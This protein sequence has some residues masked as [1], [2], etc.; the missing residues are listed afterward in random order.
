[1]KKVV[2]IIIA[3][4]CITGLLAQNP[5][6]KSD[7]LRFLLRSTPTGIERV[8]I[9]NELSAYLIIGDLYDSAMTIANEALTLSEHLNYQP[10]KASAYRKM[11]VNYTQQGD[12][13]RALECLLNSLRINEALK[14]REEIFKLHNNIGNMYYSQG[15]Y[16]SALDYFMKAYSYK[17]D[18]GLTNA[19]IGNTYMAKKDFQL[20]IRYLQKALIIYSKDNNQNGIADMLSN[21]GTIYEYKNENDTALCYYRKS[22]KI[23]EEIRD[24]QGQCDLLGGIGDILFKQKKY[25][26]AI[27]Y[28]NKSLELAYQIG[29]LISA[30]QTECKLNEI[31]DSIG[32]KE[33]AYLHYRRYIGIKEDLWN[34]EESKKTVRVEMNFEFAK[35][36]AVANAIHTEE[37]K[38]Q[39][40][41]RNAFIIGFS[42]ILIFSIFIFRS[43]KKTRKQK[44]IIET[45]KKVVEEQQKEVA[46]NVNYAAKLQRAMLPSEEYINNS[47][48]EN[49]L[50]F[51]PKDGVSGD[52][53]FN[54]RDEESI[55]F[56]SCD[57]TGH[58][59]SA[60]LTV[61]LANSLLNNIVRERK[62]SRPDIILNTLRSEIIKSLNQS[63]AEEERKD[64]I[65][66]SLCRIT[67]M[68][69]EC[70]CANN[71]VYI[72]RN[73][74]LIE[75]KSDRFPV[76][77]YVTDYPFTLK[78]FD[79]QKSDLII[80][81]SD[82]FVDQFNSETGKK[83]MSKRFKEWLIE[84]SHLEMSQ[85][86]T[87]LECR[88][89]AWKG[90]EHQIDDV[91][92]FGVRV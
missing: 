58:G 31:Y 5:S 88:F 50:I 17:K 28:E 85:I 66:I 39:Q 78:T 90:T 29:Y 1:M 47:F 63:G 19:N 86:K 12:Y 70:A 11:G 68:K 45:Q 87:E 2:A 13:A 33:R 82:G 77:K 26:E 38:N 84:L 64:G 14:N 23:K 6:R 42:L 16:S 24:S 91:T 73:T 67:G 3:L 54:Y 80:T 83:L 27:V 20:S 51:F 71:P 60:S 65:D 40:T 79:L 55:Y 35:K 48:P 15:N 10:G 9:L 62:I 49:L 53:Y 92:V 22:L 89:K 61:S 52:F 76:G 57:A 75:I 46:D 21:I 72:I 4:G 37:I 59:I 25:K 8:D 30:Q 81:F 34:E 18:D 69:L 56:A 43:Y 41:I 7:S 44:R 32:D 36:R 74:E